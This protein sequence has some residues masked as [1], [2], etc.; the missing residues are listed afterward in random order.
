MAMYICT[1]QPEKKQNPYV[2]INVNYGTKMR[3][4]L[5]FMSAE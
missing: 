3:T 4:A 5:S 2:N 1:M